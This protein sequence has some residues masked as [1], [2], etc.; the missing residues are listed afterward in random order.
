MAI[1]KAP[2]PGIFDI[3]AEIRLSIYEY[4]LASFK[5][6]DLE[7]MRRGR[8]YDTH[9][10]SKRPS[11]HRLH[12]DRFKY[13]HE[14][15]LAIQE[16]LAVLR[17]CKLFH[18]E[19]AP[20]VYKFF[21]QVLDTYHADSIEEITSLTLAASKYE[22]QMPTRINLRDDHTFTIAGGDLKLLNKL[23][24]M[25]VLERDFRPFTKRITQFLTL[26]RRTDGA[27]LT[28]YFLSNNHSYPLDQPW[29]AD[30]WMSGPLTTL[31]WEN[32]GAERWKWFYLRYNW[33]AC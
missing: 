28:I 20:L 19:C 29:E 5:E 13:R 7:N 12:W 21:E 23:Y 1:V 24:S 2:S 26:R 27:E 33:A 31:D 30:L 8:M 15:S 4:Y 3:P 9:S 32:D 17:V 14:S 11:Y 18:K 6:E 10:K 16:V 25:G 22:M